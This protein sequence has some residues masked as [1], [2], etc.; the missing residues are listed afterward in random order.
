MTACDAACCVR[1]ESAIRAM[2][3]LVVPTLPASPGCGC[4]RALEH[5][6]ITD[7]AKIPARVK[8]DL[9][10]IIGRSVQSIPDDHVPYLTVGLEL[11]CAVDPSDP[12][13]RF[14]VDWQRAI[15]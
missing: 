9:A 4:G 2:D 15:H 7:R 1:V 8:R 5:G 13:H 14:V 6:I 11:P 3:A 12:A 10:P